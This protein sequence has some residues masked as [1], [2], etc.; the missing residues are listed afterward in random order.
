M[1]KKYIIFFFVFIGISKLVFAEPLIMDGKI[2]ESWHISADNISY[3]LNSDDYIANGNVTISKTDLIFKAD[4]ICFNNVT[5]IAT[6]KGNVLISFKDDVLTGE[7]M[8]FDL[9]TETGTIFSGNI[10]LKPDN[11]VIKGDKI[12]KTG[13]QSYEIQKARI[14]SCE[15]EHP[16]WEITGKEVSVTIE[17]YGF[18]THGALW[19][20]HIPIFY[21]PLIFF[22]VKVER[23]TGL[24]S[25]N[26][27][28]SDRNGI[29][30]SIPLFVAINKNSDA[31]IYEEY[32]SERGNKIGLEYRNFFAKDSK[33][34]FLFDFLHDKKIDNNNSDKWGYTD[35]DVLRTNSNRQWF[36][37]KG[38]IG[39]PLDFLGRFD[40]DFVSDQDYLHEFRDGESG[41]DKTEQTFIKNFGR[42]LA[43]YD[44][45]FRNNGITITKNFEKSVLNIESIWFDNYYEKN[46]SDA[47]SSIYKL[48]SIK[49]NAINQ[50]LFNS[51]YV[52]LN[53]DYT[54]FYIKDDVNVQ[55][56]DI[57][58]VF[59]APIKFKHYL[60]V[61]PSVSLRETAWYIEQ[62]YNDAFQENKLHREIIDFGITANTN[63]FKIYK[64]NKSD[65]IKHL[66]KPEITYYY[67]PK[68]KN[69]VHPE[70]DYT[71]VLYRKNKIA[72]SLSNILISKYRNAS[73]DS[74]TS[75]DTKLPDFYYNQFLT[76]K[77]KQE[78]DIDTV[79]DD[80]RF[81]PLYFELLFAFN[82]LL[83]VSSDASW[84]IYG[85]GLISHN[86]SFIMQDER[87]N[88]LITEYRYTKE[89]SESLN[90]RLILALSEQISSEFYHEL[91]ML[92]SK[93][94]KW[95]VGLTYKSKC[96]AVTTT[97]KS[98][99]EDK[100]F[101]IFVYL[102]GLGGVG[103]G[104]PQL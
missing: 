40:I 91:N 42:G 76:F 75:D 23:Q 31:T 57:N 73:F 80:E 77:F 70:L 12:L 100:R 18:V 46:Q 62:D 66:I 45:P 65:A 95:G 87:D 82:Q 83:S 94:L 15:G 102:E 32:M 67:S 30:F 52:R 61:E 11:F 38:D 81:S 59:Y 93:T 43:C 98:D 50:K 71:D 20:K 26:F 96:W 44:D 14:S 41:F 33:T 64:G 6:A 86:T 21:S 2:L 24:L 79:E 47:L 89:Y 60:T 8:E 49:Y 101:S 1:L 97:Y 4:Y 7:S 37:A 13:K 25:P 3:N 27:G 39:L 35:D 104:A 28:Y 5:K 99:L 69:E 9:K 78:Y 74:I 54:F 19:V 68:I 53:S 10:I 88:K 90:N 51:L 36:R 56:I 84:S 17:G 63:F 29:E 48:P 85:D 22:P 103:A 72:Y 55:R 92:D 34:I 16:D 58:P